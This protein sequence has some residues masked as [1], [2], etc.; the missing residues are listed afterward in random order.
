MLKDFFKKKEKILL[1]IGKPFKNK[2]I[3]SLFLLKYI[4]SP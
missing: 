3:L 1:K 4:K 2:K